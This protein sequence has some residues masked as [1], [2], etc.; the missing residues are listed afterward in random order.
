MTGFRLSIRSAAFYWRAHL[1]VIVGTAISGAVLV[2]AM[3]V[4]DSVKYSLRQSALIRLGNVHHA[5]ITQ[6]RFVTQT[7]A[8]RIEKETGAATAPVLLLRG[9]A[10]TQDAAGGD[11][12]QINNVQVIGIDQR[13]AGFGNGKGALPGPD[14]IAVG[15]KLAVTL[16]L[17]VGDSLSIRVGKPSLFPGDAPLSMRG[18]G[19]T[20]RGTFTV[21]KIMTGAELGRF[22]LAANQVV[23]FNVFVNLKWL[24]EAAAVPDRVNL[25]LA[26]KGEA[27]SSAAFND[28]VRKV[29]RIEDAGLFL[30]T[31]AGQGVVQLESDRVFMDP[32]VSKAA[33]GL[34]KDGVVAVPPVSRVTLP[35]DEREGRVSPRPSADVI[36]VENRPVGQAVGVLTYLVNS[37]SRDGTSG[38]VSTPYSFMSAFSPSADRSLGPVPPGMADDEIILNRW[39]ADHLSART[40][41]TVM[42][43]Y[44]ELTAANKFVGKS[45]EFRV[46][47]ILEMDAIAAERELSPKFPGLTDVER[48]AEWDIGMP[49][50][51][52]KVADISNEDYWNKYRATPKAFITLNAGQTKMWASRFGNLSGVRYPAGTSGS[53]AIAEGLRRQL[54]PAAAGLIFSPVRDLA[55]KAVREAMDFGQLFLGMSF[56]L[57]VAGLMLTGLLFA[58]GIQQRAAEIGVLLAVGYRPG[59]VRRLLIQEGCLTAALGSLAGALLG[60]LYTRSL[61]WGLGNYWQGAVANSVIQYHAETLTIVEGAVACF[62]CAVASM[63]IAMRRQSARPARELLSGNASL[64]RDPAAISGKAGGK[65][66]ILSWV[67]VIIAAGIITGSVM[68]GTHT[69]L[70]AFFAAGGLLLLSGLGL[71][72]L[73]LIRL[74]RIGSRFTILTLGIKNAGRRRARSL[75]A[76]GLLACGCFM[77][78]AVSSMLE[79]VG[80]DADKRES[81]TGGFAVFGVSAVPVQDDLNSPEGRKK[82]RLDGEALLQDVGI[83]SMKVHDGDDASCLNLN[84]AQTPRLIGVNPDDFAVR[85]A[86]MEES[87]GGKLWE[88]LNEQLPDGVVPGLAGDVNTAMW[89]LQKKVGREDGGTLTYRDERGDEFKVK[90]VGSLPMSLSVF[91]GSILIPA[92]A[93]TA[94]YPSES[95]YR[96]FLIDAPAGNAAAVKDL[97]SSRLSKLGFDLVSTVDRLREFYMVESTYMAMFLVLGGLGLIL[98]SAGMGIVVMR[99]IMERRGEFGLLKAVGYSTAQL[100]MVLLAEHWLILAMGLALGLLSSF[101]A[102]WPSLSA[103]GIRLPYVSIVLLAGGIIAFNVLLI[104]AAVKFAVRGSSLNALRNE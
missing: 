61:I 79:D 96:M 15:E 64:S 60:M 104:V 52:D 37:I 57:I 19:D 70:P 102:M 32:V 33:L 36:P 9:I 30:R 16:H 68:T 8:D 23:P 84:R 48:C 65:L 50:E 81:G 42:V 28:A 66:A 39:L 67:G 35:P 13:F 87:S 94:K 5:L 92:A 55:L 21:S 47:D 100:C 85:K 93:F 31:I 72:R 18:G 76:A 103:P 4:G 2:G 62:V 77:V 99:N 46:R 40:G 95:G 14:E 69:A 86:F 43:E 63:G 75:T 89:G 38:I 24:Q 88:L 41:E 3:L 80:A 53:D 97:L 78:F 98:G 27:L 56:F 34:E 58:F 7:L 73:V 29:W 71:I 59:H 1:S 82:L 22:S 44:Y 91:Q 45:R 25:L 51:K 54:D 17:K 10:M 26:G 11:G 49:L 90:L 101:A 83:V 74:D 6:G 20:S 12:R